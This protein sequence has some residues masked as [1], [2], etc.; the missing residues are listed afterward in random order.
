MS[1]CPV[2]V[3]CRDLTVRSAGDMVAAAAAAS[4]TVRITSDYS[5]EEMTGKAAKHGKA[6]RSAEMRGEMWQIET[7]LLGLPKP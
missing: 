2:N 7:E 1:S 3:L 5:E 4:R 6:E